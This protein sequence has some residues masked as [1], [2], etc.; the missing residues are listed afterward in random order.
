MKKNRLLRKVERSPFENCA[1]SL[2]RRCHRTRLFERVSGR[3][4]LAL[5][6]AE[7]NIIAF[8]VEF[9]LAPSVGE[10]QATHPYLRRVSETLVV[11]AR[12]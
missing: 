5:T 8:T 1:E 2:L 12:A 11:A 10:A 9:D 3:P 6:A 4:P 7:N